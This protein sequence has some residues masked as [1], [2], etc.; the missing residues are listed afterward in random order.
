MPK[1]LFIIRLYVG[2][3]WLEAGWGKVTSSSWVGVD[4]GKALTGFVKGSLAQT[5]GAHPEVFGWYA[6]FLKHVILP[7][8]GFWS[9][10]IAYGE[11]LVGIALIL[12]AFTVVAAFFGGFMNFNYMLAGTAGINPILFLFS[13]FLILSW[14]SVGFLSLD[15][16]IFPYIKKYYDALRLHPSL[17]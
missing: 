6:S 10:V 15:K 7:F 8:A 3:V 11:L 17:R 5:S 14:K 16:F 13:I 1:I 12:G 2:W 4:A 9:Y